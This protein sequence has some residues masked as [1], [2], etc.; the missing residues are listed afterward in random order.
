MRDLAVIIEV[1]V[2]EGQTHALKGTFAC[3]WRRLQ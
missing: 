2:L 3:L 1:E